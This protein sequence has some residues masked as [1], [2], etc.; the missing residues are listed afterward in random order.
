MYKLMLN[1]GVPTVIDV[2]ESEQDIIDTMGEYIK[3][4]PD[5]RFIVKEDSMGDRTKSDSAQYIYGYIEYAIYVEQ[6]NERLKNMSC[7]ELKRQILQSQDKPKV[8]CKGTKK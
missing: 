6:Y 2:S 3:E 4:N 5:Y 8:K 7:V 1:M